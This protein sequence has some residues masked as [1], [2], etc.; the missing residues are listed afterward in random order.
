[1]M[2]EPEAA[3]FPQ[4][5]GFSRHARAEKAGI[6]LEGRLSLTMGETSDTV[7]T[8]D[9]PGEVFGW[10]S[11]VGRKGFSTTAECKEPT[12]L[13]KVSVQELERLF[14]KDRVSEIIF[15]K[16]LAAL[17]GAR[18]IQS[19]KMISGAAQAEASVSFGTGQ[20]RKA[21]STNS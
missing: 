18:L 1:L 3:F 6:C 7:Y 9:Q 5:G 20:V 19:Y 4:E 2:V 21:E 10:S 11:L 15:F 14:E 8:V 12:K 17:L 16:Q 13:L